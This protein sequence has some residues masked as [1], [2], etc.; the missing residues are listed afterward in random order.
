MERNIGDFG[1]F[2]DFGAV[3]VTSSDQTHIQL[4]PVPHPLLSVDTT[5]IFVIAT[6]ILLTHQI[7]FFSHLLIESLFI[8]SSDIG[9][10]NTTNVNLLT[11]H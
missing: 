10:V 2:A 4:M 8:I 11:P 9:F 5:N 7:Y 6:N 1:D 3:V